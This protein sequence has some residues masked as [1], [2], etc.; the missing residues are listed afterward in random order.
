MLGEICAAVKSAQQ[1]NDK[2]NGVVYL[3][4][5]FS[6]LKSQMKF[7]NSDTSKMYSKSGILFCPNK[8]QNINR[9]LEIEKRRR[10]NKNLKTKRNK[11]DNSK[12]N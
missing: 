2:E 9:R 11:L 4:S 3:M 8:K 5:T 6:V 1:T 12:H 7:M 10:K